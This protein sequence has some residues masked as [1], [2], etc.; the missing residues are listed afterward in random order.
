MWINITR[1]KSHDEN[2]NKIY[3]LKDHGV[4]SYPIA[5]NWTTK[6]KGY[7]HKKMFKI[8]LE[9][10]WNRLLSAGL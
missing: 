1:G 8:F 4:L 10:Y 2:E 7:E 5:E 3:K 6:N 9:C